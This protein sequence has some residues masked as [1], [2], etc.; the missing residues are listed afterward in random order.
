MARLAKPYKARFDRVCS[1][2]FRIHGIPIAH[3]FCYHNHT[4]NELWKIYL[5]GTDLKIRSVEEKLDGNTL[6]KRVHLVKR[7][8]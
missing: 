1:Y 2:D 5:N 3:R 8:A 4:E 6:Y 7:G